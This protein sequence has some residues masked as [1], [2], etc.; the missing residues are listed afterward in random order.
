MRLSS[1]RI[2]LLS[3][4][5]L[6]ASALGI[7]FAPAPTGEAPHA[8]FGDSSADRRSLFGGESSR[9]PPDAAL[10]TAREAQ[11]LALATDDLRIRVVAEVSGELLPDL[12]VEVS[13]R[14]RHAGG[15]PDISIY[16][17][18]PAG[19]ERE[20]RI[21]RASI[22]ELPQLEKLVIR[23]DDGCFDPAP[24][25]EVPLD[26]WPREPLLL[27]VPA[28]GRV[29]VLVRER[30][31]ALRSMQG[32]VLVRFE[33]AGG[34]QGWR[35]A[36]LADGVSKTFACALDLALHLE[37]QSKEAPDLPPLEARGPRRVGETKWIEVQ[38]PPAP[39]Q[40]RLR[41]IDDE[42]APVSSRAVSLSRRQLIH[43][44]RR[45]LS[46]LELLSQVTAADGEVLL[47]IPAAQC[48]AESSLELAVS[49]L[50][51]ERGY[52]HG[53]I[54]IP[55]PLEAGDHDLGEL[56]LRPAPV[57]VA[58]VVLD[59]R[60]QPV[61]GARVAVREPLVDESSSE[62]LELS[63]VTT[64]EQGRFRLSDLRPE[65]RIRLQARAAGHRPSPIVEA[66]AG[67]EALVLRLGAPAIVEGSIV[68]PDNFPWEEIAVLVQPLTEAERRPALGGSTTVR[69]N[70]SFVVRHAPIGE[71]RIVF[72][73]PV[74]GELA[75]IDGVV[76]APGELS[77]DPRLQAVA[78]CIGHRELEL[79]LRDPRNPDLQL[80]SAAVRSEL[81]GAERFLARTRDATWRAWIRPEEH[82]FHLYVPGYRARRIEAHPHA[83]EIEL[84]VALRVLLPV[85][86]TL[87]PAVA[88][89]DIEA[90]AESDATTVRAPV[91]DGLAELEVP[92]SGRYRLEVALVLRA[93]AN[94]S[95]VPLALP[96]AIVAEIADRPHQELAPL[97]LD[98]ELVRSAFR[99][100]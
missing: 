2:L 68:C 39:A 23:L 98:E 59:P 31:G 51:A 44:R 5:L 74:Y 91:I 61:R 20:L 37:V 55:T 73:H 63:S 67:D 41:L 66:S 4:A 6:G 52:L 8:P 21:A 56:E 70:R 14:M 26:P 95:S 72:S 78:L 49:Y 7:F 45:P 16:R 60:E 34:G 92:T 25:L 36:T 90:H 71:V 15:H 84:D 76:L 18:T 28:H 50:H 83:Q 47:S 96:R 80:E 54:E 53:A 77:R 9:T 89:I 75:A 85:E 99:P 97:V 24:E 69:R 100:R 11:R 10:R 19:P 43:T 29:G 27:R 46:Q 3:L 58:G 82:A 13:G 33:R 65:R 17:G 93:G 57:A 35:Q 48:G 64:D 40:V 62:E 22:G 81:D 88:R 86:A 42:G 38:P 32:K 94:E 79:R 12:A 1:R 30:C 87:P